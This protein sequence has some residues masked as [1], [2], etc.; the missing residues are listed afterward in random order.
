[1]KCMIAP[2]L[3]AALILC[4][5][6]LALAGSD[7]P[8]LIGVAAAVN[9]NTEEQRSEGASR[10]LRVGTDIEQGERIDTDENGQAQLLFVDGSSFTVGSR[11]SVVVDDFVYDAATQK[12]HLGLSVGKGVFRF[13]GGHLSKDGSVDVRTPTALLGIRGAIVLI[14]VDPEAGTTLVTLLYGDHVMITG[15][16]GSYEVIRRPGF[17]LVIGRGG[18][19]SAPHRID[20]ARLSQMEAHLERHVPTLRP[21]VALARAG[22]QEV[23]TPVAALSVL[24]HGLI[25]IPLTLG[26]AGTLTQAA[27]SGTDAAVVGLPAIDV[28][29][30]RLSSYGATM[31]SA[32]LTTSSAG[33]S[34]VVV[35]PLTL[36]TLSTVTTSGLSVAVQPIG[37]LT[38][39]GAVTS[40]TTGTVSVTGAGHIGP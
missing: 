34:A 15:I 8:L 21:D 20:S 18:T 40:T 32:S 25:S 31:T 17:G 33:L 11:A 27:I 12:G 24:P 16:D 14:D 3:L 37:S 6:P 9:A 10:T 39:V 5:P 7:A 38:S 13:V 19:P 29:S 1:M 36:P 2:P 4:A 30:T 28:D 26:T 23:A 35:T 22:L